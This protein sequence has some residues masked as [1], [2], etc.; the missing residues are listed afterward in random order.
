M[1]KIKSEE[2]VWD[3]KKIFFAGALLLLILG[4]GVK[5]FLLDTHKLDFSKD[6]KGVSSGPTPVP[7]NL[8][9]TLQDKL[10]GIK[11]EVQNINLAEIA[12]SSPQVQKAINDL[13]ALEGYPK[14]QAK[15]LCQKVCSSF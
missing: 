1:E 10:E 7:F 12:S 3:K 2:S 5:I 11:E 15:E 4:F 14:S 13:K 8:R 6:V 9:Q